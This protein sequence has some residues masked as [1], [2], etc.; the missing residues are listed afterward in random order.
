[1]ADG[2]DRLVGV[3]KVPHQRVVVLRLDVGKRGI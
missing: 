1:V 2:R 3:K